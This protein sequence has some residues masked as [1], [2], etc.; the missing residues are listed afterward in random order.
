MKLSGRFSKLA[1]WKQTDKHLKS[2]TFDLSVLFEL[3]ALY[4][5]KQ[6]KTLNHCLQWEIKRSEV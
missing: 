5:K 4:D 2:A 1:T 6:G 3:N